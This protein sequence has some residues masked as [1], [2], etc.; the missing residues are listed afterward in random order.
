M[1]GKSKYFLSL[2]FVLIV[3]TA[4]SQLFKGYAVAGLNLSKVEGDRINNGM[5]AFNKPGANAGVGVS[6]DLGLNFSAS[7]EVLFSQKGAYQKKG[8]PDSL[9][10]AYLTKLNYAEIPILIHYTDKDKYT[11]GTGISYSR[12]VGVKWVV[13]GRTLSNSINDG[14][15][16]ENNIDWIADF[17]LRV[18]KSLKFNFRYQYSLRTIWSGE[19]DELLETV[20]GEKQDMNQ[21]NSMISVR[22]IWVFNEKLAKQSK[23]EIKDAKK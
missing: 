12:L 1:K 13:N 23:K 15:F 9:Q 22:F 3:L 21:R 6:L 5:I 14:F 2:L 7:M 19:E 11:F 18:W 8:N 20:G 17:R 4:H 10:P 16:S